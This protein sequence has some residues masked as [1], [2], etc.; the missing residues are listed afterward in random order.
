M[1]WG[2]GVGGSAQ[3]GRDAIPGRAP[4]T[5]FLKCVVTP[6][7]PPNVNK[8]E[9]VLGGFQLGWVGVRMGTSPSDISDIR[10][11]VCVCV[12]VHVL[13]SVRASMLALVPVLLFVPV[14]V[15]ILRLY[16]CLCLHLCLCLYL[17]LRLFLPLRLHSA[18][19]SAWSVSMSLG[20]RLHAPL[21]VPRMGLCVG[22]LISLQPSGACA[23]S[24]GGLEVEWRQ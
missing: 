10:R 2:I 4:T 1:T 14:S 24:W 11:L 8:R 19:V 9:G 23:P 13:V 12:S 17:C 20:V 6:P 21:I 3:W 16:G 18:C 15:C 7:A 5:I 22:V